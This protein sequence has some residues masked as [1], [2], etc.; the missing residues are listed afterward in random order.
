MVQD[1]WQAEVLVDVAKLHNRTNY[2]KLKWRNG[3]SHWTSGRFKKRNKTIVVTAG[4]DDKQHLPV[5]L[6][7]LA[8]W[9]T[10][11]SRAHGRRFW[12]VAFDLYKRYSVI[13]TNE[14]FIK[15]EFKYMKMAETVFNELYS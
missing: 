4:K 2:P 12:Q 5:L 7:E 3:S 8:H 9:L 6:H 13:K 11:R 10:P 1:S 15:R 14:E